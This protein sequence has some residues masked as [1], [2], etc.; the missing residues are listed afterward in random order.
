M[1]SKKHKQLG[2]GLVEVLVATGILGIVSFAI[3]D[4]ISNA[5]KSQ[6]AVQAKDQQRELTGFL[7]NKLKLNAAC[8]STFNGIAYAA[9]MSIPS[10]KNESGVVIVQT[11]GNDSTGQLKIEDIKIKNWIPNTANPLSGTAELQVFL[12]RNTSGNATKLLRPDTIYLYMLKN[13]SN[14][15]V[16]CTA[17][18]GGLVNTLWQKVGSTD[19]IEY[20]AGSVAV[21]S[22]LT[23]GGEVKIGTTTQPCDISTEGSQRYNSVTKNMEFCDGITWKPFFSGSMQNCIGAYSAC[24]A[25]NTQTYN[26]IQP[27]SGGGSP[28]LAGNGATRTCSVV[29]NYSCAAG[30]S[31]LAPDCQQAAAPTTTPTTALTCAYTCQGSGGCVSAPCQ[32]TTP[33]NNAGTCTP[34]F[35]VSWGGTCNVNSG[36]PTS[37]TNTTTTYSCPTGSTLSP[38]STCTTP[39][40]AAC[41]ASHP[42]LSADRLSCNL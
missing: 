3:V 28:C 12:S 37:V 32:T 6:T 15:I 1:G 13:A 42:N 5:M 25:T 33:A 14:G 35:Y 18:D 30:W 31:V 19:N 24:D 8:T 21:A 27:A 9:D 40:F 22:R 16:D 23:V 36:Q 26:V 11:G 38:P 4:V 17:L 41:P 29:P 34:S 2:F 10:I 7:K 39:A 20:T